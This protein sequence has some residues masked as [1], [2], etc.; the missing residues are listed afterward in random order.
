MVFLSVLVRAC[1]TLPY[2]HLRQLAQSLPA[3]FYHIWY[4]SSLF[5]F[6]KRPM[7]LGV[8]SII[9]DLAYLYYTRKHGA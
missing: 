3:L 4:H 9:F 7:Y 1:P 5:T 2:L 8:I 6:Q